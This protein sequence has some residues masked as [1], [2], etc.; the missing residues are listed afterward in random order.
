MQAK[1]LRPYGATGSAARD[2]CLLL[3]MF[4]KPVEKAGQFSSHRGDGFGSAETGAQTAVLRSQI[5]LAAEQ[6][7]GRVSERHGSPIDYLSGAAVQDF[8]PA[9]LVGGTQSQP[10]GELLL[11]GESAQVRA[12][13]AITVCAVR[14]SMPLFVPS[15]CP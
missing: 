14:T 7:R 12:S 4:D 3:S 8:A 10:T 6:G 15:R 9:L 2:T 5:T 11:A 1:L 13:S